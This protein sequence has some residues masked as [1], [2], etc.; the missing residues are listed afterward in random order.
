MRRDRQ[1]RQPKPM[2]STLNITNVN[3][4]V[5]LKNFSS[6][7]ERYIE[8]SLNWVWLIYN[9]EAEYLLTIRGPLETETV[10]SETEVGREVDHDLVGGRVKGWRCWYVGTAPPHH[11]R[12][13]VR[14]WS[15]ADLGELQCWKKRKY[16][17]VSEILFIACYVLSKIGLRIRYLSMN[18]THRYTIHRKDLASLQCSFLTVESL[19]IWRNKI[20]W[21]NDSCVKNVMKTMTY[22]VLTL[23]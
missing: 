7:E 18:I 15:P 9:N 8:V 21:Y 22:Y 6:P 10:V 19:K 2:K 3:F 5:T 16:N 14:R 13:Y 1:Q 17:I 4:K 20:S 12:W 23:T 11:F